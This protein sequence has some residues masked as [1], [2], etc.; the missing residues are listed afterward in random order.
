[1]G[2]HALLAANRYELQ[3][4]NS[5]RRVVQRELNTA[6]QPIPFGAG[7]IWPFSFTL[8]QK[9]IIYELFDGNLSVQNCW[10]MGI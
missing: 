7:W 8:N 5:V 3:K 6:L 9:G 2:R 4:P 1:M 10:H